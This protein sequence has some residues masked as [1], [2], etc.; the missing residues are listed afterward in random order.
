[1]IKMLLLL[2][3]LSF[4]DTLTGFWGIPFGSSIETTKKAMI[5]RGTLDVKESTKEILLYE[6]VRFAGRTTKWIMIGFVNNKMH[7]VRIFFK[8][9]VANKSIDL[10]QAIKREL[11]EKYF[12]ST[13][14]YVDFK[15]PYEEGDG[16]EITAVRTGAADYSCYWFFT[17]P[18]EEDPEMQNIIWL[19]LDTELYVILGYQ[20]GRLI[21]TVTAKSKSDY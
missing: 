15:S 7:T 8:T 20:D 9:D 5:G 19:E 13:S 18:G 12:I 17:R 11:N 14:D 21:K 1:M 3:A 6:K 16:Y 10:Y 2:V 4:A